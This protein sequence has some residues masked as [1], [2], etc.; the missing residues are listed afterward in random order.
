[1]MEM[2]SL[3]DMKDNNLEDTDEYREREAWIEQIC[4]EYAGNNLK[5]LKMFISKKISAF[6]ISHDDQR[7]LDFLSMANWQLYMLL[8]TFDPDKN[9]SEQISSSWTKASP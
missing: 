3:K 9:D 8:R 6:G 4:N 1:M 5:K 7:Y 2:A